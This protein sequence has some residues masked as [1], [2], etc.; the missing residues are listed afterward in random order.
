MSAIFLL[1]GNGLSTKLN[2]DYTKEELIQL[3]QKLNG[4]EDSDIP[5]FLFFSKDRL[6]NYTKENG[7]PRNRTEKRR[8]NRTKA[9]QRSN[10]EI[11]LSRAL[12]QIQKG[13]NLEIIT[14]WARVLDIL[15]FNDLDPEIQECT[16]IKTLGVTSRRTRYSSCEK[17]R[18]RISRRSFRRI[19]RTLRTSTTSTTKTKSEEDFFERER[20]NN[21][22]NKHVH[23]FQQDHE[24]KSRIKQEEIDLHDFLRNYNMHEPEEDEDDDDDDDEVFSENKRERD[25]YRQKRYIETQDKNENQSNDFH[26]QLKARSPIQ[27][28][29]FER[30]RRSLSYTYSDEGECFEEGDEA[31]TSETV[32]LCHVCFKTVDFGPDV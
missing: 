15:L 2:I 17:S 16:V 7:P 26:T 10:A 12:Q 20:N 31:S 29:D 6:W 28:V 32:Y 13:R 14:R 30:M 4:G 24:R 11:T 9:R 19:R 22:N 1:T 27:T 3:Y 25:D 21:Y 18:R 5:D 8:K 23:D